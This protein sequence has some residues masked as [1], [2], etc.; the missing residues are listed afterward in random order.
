[1]SPRDLLKFAEDLPSLV[2]IRLHSYA[3][4]KKWIGVLRWS[5]VD[6]A[7]QPFGRLKVLECIVTD[8]ADGETLEELRQVIESRWLAGCLCTLRIWIRWIGDGSLDLL[9]QNL[10]DIFGDLEQDGLEVIVC[11]YAGAEFIEYREDME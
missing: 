9:S 7:Q 1:M 4:D 6:L 3:V 8:G 10:Y 2:E 5:D 11:K